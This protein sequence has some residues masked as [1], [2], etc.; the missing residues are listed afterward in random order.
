MSRE[1][2]ALRKCLGTFHF[3]SYSL[4]AALEQSTFM[5]A[6]DVL[7]T[8]VVV[9]RGQSTNM[10]AAVFRTLSCEVRHLS[11]R[12]ATSSRR[13]FVTTSTLQS[14][15][16]QANDD[17]NPIDVAELLS[18]PTWSVFSLLPPRGQVPPAAPEITPRQLHHLL[19]LSALP[20]PRTPAE[21]SR[22]LA[23][24]SS[25][26]HFAKEIQKVDTTGVEP[27]RSLRDETRAGEEEAELGLDRLRA[28]LDEEE[29][30]GKFHRRIR[31]MKRPERGDEEDGWDVL[32][33]AER[34]VG[35][36]F[37]VEGGKEG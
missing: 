5:K 25:Q 4:L 21:E 20:P 29:V 30:R 32:S 36:V 16:S 11:T 7:R 10:S 22:M 34:K 2:C 1:I 18:R 12:R 8:H 33:A 3:R 9:A 17:S 26:L 37:V 19:R 27:L 14:Q 24:L 13:H 35:R 31:R 28:A 6:G 15:S 23:T